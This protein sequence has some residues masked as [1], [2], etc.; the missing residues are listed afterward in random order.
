MQLCSFGLRVTGKKLHDNGQDQ[1]LIEITYVRLTFCNLSYLFKK[2]KVFINT[3][4]ALGLAVG[5]SR[6]F[7]FLRR[8]FL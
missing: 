3:F 1:R 6:A 5:C 4:I 7:S 2:M 8:G